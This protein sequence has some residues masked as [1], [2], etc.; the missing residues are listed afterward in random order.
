MTTTTNV[1]PLAIA[2]HIWALPY[3]SLGMVT[4]YL[5]S[6]SDTQLKG[7]YH[8]ER[9]ALG[10]IDGHPLEDIYHSLNSATNPVCLFSS[11]VWNH[12]LNL[13]AAAE[14]KRRYPGS[15]IIFGGPEVPKFDG[16]TEGFL[17]DNSFIDIAVLGEGEASCA[18]ILAALAEQSQRDLSVLAEI[19]GIV[20]SIAGS[21]TRTPSRDRIKDVNILPS[22]YLSG[23]FGDWFQDF[24]NAILETNRGCPYGCTYCDWGSATL[25]KITRFTPERV[26]AEI[27]F[28]ASR[29]SKVIFIAD[30][31]FGM[32]EQDIEISKALVAISKRTGYPKKLNTNFAKNGGRRLMA[33]IKILHEGGLR[34]LSTKLC[35]PQRADWKTGVNHEALEAAKVMEG[36]TLRSLP[37]GAGSKP[38]SSGI[39]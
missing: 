28:L 6:H 38:P 25:Q 23:E 2:E 19:K 5:R 21:V 17:A 13:H 14:I 33:V 10:G 24:S 1:F 7:A 9:I 34:C 4:A 12:K 31:N 37:T 27:E 16:D 26:I 18:E 39:G 29:R 15:L 30:A 3:L 20:F 35:V 32:L 22:P 11:Y 36:P 8:I